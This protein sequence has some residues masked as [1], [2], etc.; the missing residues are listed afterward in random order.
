MILELAKT[1]THGDIALTS[2]DFEQVVAN[3]NTDDKVPVTIGHEM[4]DTSYAAGWV[5]DVI[6]E[7]DKLIGEVELM[8]WAKEDFE[9]GRLGNWSIGLAK[10]DN[11]WYLH[12]LAMLGGVPPKIKGLKTVE[13][14]DKVM[15]F[16]HMHT[17]SDKLE[18]LEKQLAIYQSKER[19]GQIA[20]F[21][22]ALVGKMPKR[23][24]DNIIAF[25]SKDHGE[26][27]LFADADRGDSGLI[28]LLT[29]AFNNMPKLTDGM[30]QF[31]DL[32]K[33]VSAS[34]DFNRI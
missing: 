30:T 29:E 28:G 27:L 16:A 1:G 14:S 4:D 33:E 25:A 6:I 32:D 3:F 11:G 13:M 24:T 19:S 7:D 22:D 15:M 31:S 21:K 17:Y 18:Q 34:I 26:T 20:A 9:A 23:Y 5:I 12:H 8:D 2:E 10:G